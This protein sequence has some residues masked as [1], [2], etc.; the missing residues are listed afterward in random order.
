MKV[1]KE[2]KGLKSFISSE[3]RNLVSFV[4]KYF[5]ERY[6]DVTAE[7]IVQDVAANLFSKLDFDEHLENVAGYVYRS[8]RNRITDFQRKA[9]KEIPFEKFTN[10]NG[11]EYFSE[12]IK[13]T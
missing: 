6:Y 12:S 13:C 9:K 2:N 7:D 5:N 10:D 4:R 8:I 3:Y 1:E 11:E